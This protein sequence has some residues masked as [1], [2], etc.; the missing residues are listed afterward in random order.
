MRPLSDADDCHL[1]GPRVEV[2][3][4]KAVKLIILKKYAET[5]QKI[6]LAV[7]NKPACVILDMWSD[8]GELIEYV[9]PPEC[10]PATHTCPEIAAVVQ[11]Y[12]RDW[13]FHVVGIVAD[14]ALEGVSRQLGV[15]YTWCMAHRLALVYKHAL[16]PTLPAIQKLRSWITE[17]HRSYI[18]MRLFK[19]HCESLGI[20]KRLITDTKVRWLS[21]GLMVM[22]GVQLRLPLAMC[23]TDKAFEDVVQ[24]PKSLDFSTDDWKILELVAE[25]TKPAKEAIKRIQA[26]A[27]TLATGCLAIRSLHH[28]IEATPVSASH[29]TLFKMKETLIKNLDSYFVFKD[30]LTTL[31]TFLDP[32]FRFLNLW[33]DTEKWD[34]INKLKD[35]LQNQMEPLVV[36]IPHKETFYDCLA[37]IDKHIKYWYQ[38]RSEQPTTVTNS[39]IVLISRIK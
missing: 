14:G 5:C 18:K 31:I 1:W 9:C 32:R 4:R 39:G 27:A 2:K 19:Q 8:C 15:S 24:P 22:R 29:H 25:L 37:Y 33:T 23:A 30:D 10:M 35:L 26:H 16:D 11:K 38:Q 28:K 12:Q 17:L 7:Q 13:N 21:T 6:K 36:E 20:R 3:G 34:V